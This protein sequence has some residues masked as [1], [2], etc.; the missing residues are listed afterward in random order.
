MS[1]KRKKWKD[2]V[3]EAA[4][5]LNQY[6]L[7]N[8]KPLDTGFE[9]LNENGLGGLY[10]QDIIVIAGLPGSG[11]TWFL[12]RIEKN[13]QELNPDS[14]I[15]FLRMAWEMSTFR[16]VTRLLKQK[17]NKLMTD[18]LLKTPSDKDRQIFKGILDQEREQE[19]DHIEEA[20]TP[21][22]FFQEAEEFLKENISKDSCIISIDHIALAR[23]KKGDVKQAVDEIVGH[24]ILLKQRYPNVIFIILSQLNREIEG[25]TAEKDAAPRMSDLYQSSTFGHGA[26]MIIVVDNPF[27]RKLHNYMVVAKDAYDYMFDFFVEKDKSL[28]SKKKWASFE[29]FNTI[30]YHY[31]KVRT[32]DGNTYRDVFAER[33]G[34]PKM[35]DEDYSRQKMPIPKKADINEF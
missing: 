21:E 22:E 28:D 34:P 11:K 18:I 12:Q 7:G 16:L 4:K 26:D 5:K 13:L 6:Q 24:C 1:S 30:F 19:A 20:L 31:L 15:A 33:I 17:T 3:N 8:L 14:K 9:H 32:P 25:R 10:N 35:S 2:A 27:R 29:T 23:A